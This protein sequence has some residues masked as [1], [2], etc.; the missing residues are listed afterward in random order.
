MSSE[1]T[2]ETEEKRERLRKSRKL[3]QCQ[4]LSVAH[5]ALYLEGLTPLDRY[6]VQNMGAI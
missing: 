5:R 1:E 4:K 3:G 6:E 2:Y